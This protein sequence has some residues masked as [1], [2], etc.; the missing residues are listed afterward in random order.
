MCACVTLQLK[1][2]VDT[3][4][5]LEAMDT[6]KL[7]FVAGDDYVKA[8]LAAWTASAP[9]RATG[10]KGAYTEPLVEP[11][12]ESFALNMSSVVYYCIESSADEASSSPAAPPNQPQL[13]EEEDEDEEEDDDSQS[14]PPAEDRKSAAKV[15]FAGPEPAAAEIPEGVPPAEQRPA[16]GFAEP[17]PEPEPEP[18]AGGVS[19]AADTADSPGDDAPSGGGR[20]ARMKSYSA[21]EYGDAMRADAAADVTFA[22]GTADAPASGAP[23]ITRLKSY[24]A[25]E[26]GDAMRADGEP[27]VTFAEDTAEELASGGDA[28]GG[29]K[30]ARLKSYGA[31]EYGD[32]L[33]AGAAAD[34]TFAEGTAEPE[35]AGAGDGQ[36]SKKLA[37]LKSYGADEYKDILAAEA[38]HSK[39]VGEY[40]AS[41][42]ETEL[43]DHVISAL[44]E[45]DYE[46]ATW[47]SELQTM[48][49]EGILGQFLGVADQHRFRTTAAS[50]GQLAEAAAQAEALS[51]GKKEL[52]LNLPDDTGGDDEAPISLGGATPGVPRASTKARSA[53]PASET[54][55]TRRALAPGQSM[56]HL[57]L[58]DE[59]WMCSVTLRLFMENAAATRTGEFIEKAV[60]SSTA[61]GKERS[62][63]KA[64][65]TKWLLSRKDVIPPDNASVVAGITTD[66]LK[67][68]VTINSS[69]KGIGR[70]KKKSKAKSSASAG[71]VVAEA[72][73]PAEE[74]EEE[75][76]E[77]MV[78]AMMWDATV[79][80]SKFMPRDV[81]KQLHGMLPPF[82]QVRTNHSYFTF[83]ISS[84]SRHHLVIISSSR[85]LLVAMLLYRDALMGWLR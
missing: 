71:D 53:P 43:A 22:E 23:G 60:L 41:I 21:G 64:V 19:F 37:R 3:I 26:Y 2:N 4:T 48:K 27:D 24:G 47:V 75:E 8:A 12:A 72:A 67:Q 74:E 44:Q 10:K 33:R 11:E 84:S 52:G 73:A 40:L 16:V 42:G 68:R 13:L 5:D 76:E 65:L 30:I 25:G 83:I 46:P 28:A 18:S 66:D 78:Y 35:A 80:D 36:P 62:K 7:H 31:G 6:G 50:E 85:H 57:V 17:E 55:G 54:F 82:Q 45:A 9:K 15:G 77:D 14:P 69:R 51:G 56:L 32:A 49:D 70:L 39:A 38:T 81:I 61:D 59:D 79:K 1:I 29:K 20:L 63:G 34:V 58:V